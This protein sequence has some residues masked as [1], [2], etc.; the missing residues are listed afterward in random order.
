MSRSLRRGA[1]AALVLAAIVPLSACA[2][3]NSADT[4]EIKPDNVSATLG[5][6]ILLNNIVV[7]TR[8]SPT[9]EYSG[10]ATVTV[11]INNGGSAPETLK[12][13]TIGDAQAVLTDAS[14]ARVNELVIPAGGSL[15]IGGEGQ[16]TAQASSAKVTLGGLTPTS[17]TFGSAGKVSADASVVPARSFY[18]GFGPKVEAPASPSAAVTGAA[19]P[20]GAATPTGAA[21]PGGSAS[22]G[23]TVSGSA[24][25]N[26]APTGAAKPSGSAS[27]TAATH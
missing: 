13:I 11:N 23:A 12:S 14:G 5:S 4:M 7:V 20:T 17:F 21:S 22:P 27:S 9:A 10:P 18:A 25:P 6:N 2:A 8:V 24:T 1:I 15:L 19:S 26:A 16:P 3:G